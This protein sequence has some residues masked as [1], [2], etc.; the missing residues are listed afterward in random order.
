METTQTY[1]E[2]TDYE[3]IRAILR[4]VAEGQKETREQLKETDRITRE[5]AKLIGNLGGRL[6]DMVEH[7]VAPNLQEKFGELGVDFEKAYPNAK[8]K[9]KKNNIYAEVDITLENSEKV[10]LVEVKNKLT[11][12]DI[13]E[14][15]ERMKKV[16]TYAVLH[17]DKRK[18]YGAV[19]GVIMTDNERAFAFKNGFYVIEPSGETFAIRKPEGDYSIREW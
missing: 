17:G 7:L 18:F 10:M 6:G 16:S 5:N 19:A 9:D 13:A 11:T 3:T 1:G 8:I 12:E 14:H 2:S 15:I 4:E